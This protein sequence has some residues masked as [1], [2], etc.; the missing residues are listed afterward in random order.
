[1][2]LHTNVTHAWL[3]YCIIILWE[4]ARVIGMYILHVCWDYLVT[5]KYIFSPCVINNWEKFIMPAGTANWIITYGATCSNVS[6]YLLRTKPSKPLYMYTRSTMSLINK[7]KRFP[8]RPRC[9]EWMNFN[10]IYFYDYCKTM[11]SHHKIIFNQFFCEHRVKDIIFF[12][13][14]MCLIWVL[15]IVMAKLEID[16]NKLHLRIN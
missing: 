4:I 7:G 5:K 8:W 10:E 12:H 1:M 13:L 6:L 15:K 11:F 3:R 16:R 2:C 9:I 14:Q